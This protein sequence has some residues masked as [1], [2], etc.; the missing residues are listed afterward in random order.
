VQARRLAARASVTGGRRRSRGEQAQLG[1][2]GLGDVAGAQATQ[3][4][5]GRSGQERRSG[6]DWWRLGRAGRLGVAAGVWGAGR[7]GW[8]RVMGD[9][10]WR[11][12]GGGLAGWAAGKGI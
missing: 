5:L 8:G 3:P 1:R 12:T 7:R 9:G 2:S 4:Q 11:D 6:L 10:G